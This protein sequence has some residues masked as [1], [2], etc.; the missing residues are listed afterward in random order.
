MS[1]ITLILLSVCFTI[2]IGLAQIQF[3]VYELPIME[4]VAISKTIVSPFGETFF[5]CSSRSCGESVAGILEEGR[6]QPVDIEVDGYIESAI[7]DW[8]G[9]LWMIVVNQS[10][11]LYLYEFGQDLEPLSIFGLDLMRGSHDPDIQ[12][13]LTDKIEFLHDQT[14][15]RWDENFGLISCELDDH[16]IDFINAATYNVFLDVRIVAS[17]NTCLFLDDGLEVMNTIDLPL[18]LDIISIDDKIFAL[19]QFTISEINLDGD[20]QTV[21][22][23]GRM[24]TGAE[25]LVY[26]NDDLYV[27]G[28]PSFLY[29]DELLGYSSSASFDTTSIIDEVGYIWHPSVTQTNDAFYI[30]GF[31][32]SSYHMIKVTSEEAKVP[33]LDLS[34]NDVRIMVVDTIYDESRQSEYIRC[35]IEFDVYNGSLDTINFFTA[36][37]RYEGSCTFRRPSTLIETPIAPFEKVVISHEQLIEIELEYINNNDWPEIWALSINGRPDDNI[38]DNK[39]FPSV[40]F[41]L[42][43]VDPSEEHAFISFY[44][45][46]CTDEI[47]IDSQDG[48]INYKLNI[49]NTNGQLIKNGRCETQSVNVSD[50]APGQYILLIIAENTDVL[51]SSQFIKMD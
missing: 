36:T 14:W 46:P 9:N 42:S 4:R 2:Q 16:G 7:Y 12:M 3:D 44:P 31:G 20:I 27:L 35:S 10:Q 32:E 28:S 25:K 50:L 41:I 29:W 49:L 33:K 51:Y 24:T 5:F 48:L 21:R 38:S 18:I 26:I 39:I 15:Y 17:S 13:F 30:T 6:F 1:Q 40:D 19:S 47:I 45:N 23:F 11:Q 37:M 34:L 43:S 22:N 8:I